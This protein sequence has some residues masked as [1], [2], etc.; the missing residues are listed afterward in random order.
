MNYCL[1]KTCYN[2]PYFFKT[3]TQDFRF[4]LVKRILVL[5]NILISFVMLCL[6]FSSVSSVQAQSQVQVKHYTTDEGL[7]HNIGFDILQDSK[8]YIWIGTDNG[9][10]R[11]DG[12]NFKVYRNSDGLLSNYVIG[13]TEAKDSSLWIGTWKGGVNVLK[14]GIIRTPKIDFPLFNI[15]YIGVNN[16]QLLLSDFKNKVFPY[17]KSANGWKY[18]HNKKK[19]F[20]Y[21]K[22]DSSIVYTDIRLSEKRYKQEGLKK[23]SYINTYLAQDHSILFFGNYPGVWKYHNDS[24]FTPF[25]PEF[26]KQEVIFCF[27]QDSDQ[28]Y[29]LGSRGKIITIDRQKKV[30]V[31]SQGLPAKYIYMLKVNSRGQIYFITNS[32]ARGI[33]DGFYSYNPRTKELIDLKERLALKSLPS[34]IEIDKEDNVWLTTNGDG[35]YCISSSLVKNYDDK[36]G[37]S[38]VFVEAINE[39]PLGNI[40]VGTLDGLYV[41]KKEQLNKLQLFA[42][43]ARY[44]VAGL[45]IDRNKKLLVTGNGKGSFL[46]EANSKG[47]K[48]SPKKNIQYK[49]YQDSKGDLW[50]VSSGAR[51]IRQRYLNSSSV[52][53]YEWMDLS[54]AKLSVNQIFEYNYQIWLATNAGLLSFEAAQFSGS[55][56][57]LQFTDTLNTVHGL[58]TNNVKMVAKDAQGVLWVATSNGLCK[59]QNNKFT[60]FDK[61]DGLV[62]NDCT[63]LLFD[64][65]GRLWIGT[66]KGLSCF[67]G[68]KFT[69]YNHKTGLISSDIHCLFLDSKQRLWVGTSKGVS[70]MNLSAL[71]QKTT[72]PLVY[73][74]AIEIN[75]AT[76]TL[77]PSL[78]KLD[79]EA[80][81]RVHFN[82][83]TYTYPEGVRFQYRLNGGRWQATSLNSIDFNALRSG[84]YTFEVRAKKMNSDWSLP[85]KL[86][87][88]VMP[89]FWWTKSAITAYI[90]LF[91]L[92]TYLVVKWRFRRLQK[93][94]L[95]LEALVT[96][97]TYELEQQKEEIEAQSNQLK[98]MDKMKS[99]FFSNI[100]HE[101]RTPLTLIIAPARKLLE[102]LNKQYIK[103]YSQTIIAN[104]ER[105]LR[106]INQLLDLA[107]LENKKMTPRLNIM[108]VTGYLQGIVS[109]FYVLAR[110]KNIELNLKGFSEEIVCEFDDD[111]L[112]KVFLN[113]L[114]NAFKFT[115]ENGRISVTVAKKAEMLEVSVEDT[116]IGIPEKSL[117]FI[118][119]RFYQLDTT[120]TREY[121]G[122]GVGLALT[123]E[124]IELHQGTI[125]VNSVLGKGTTFWVKLPIIT[126]A[127]PQIAKMTEE[128]AGFPSEDIVDAGLVSADYEQDFASEKKTAKDKVLIVE[129][130][131]E[132]RKFICIQLAPFYEVLEAN[133]GEEG[134][135]KALE[136]VPDLI[137]SDIMMPKVDG[138]ELLYTLRNNPLTSH[139]SILMLSAKASEESKIKGLKTG[140][141]D[142]LTKPFNVQELLLKIKNTLQRREQLRSLFLQSVSKPHVAIEP[143]QVTSVSMDEAFLTKAIET[144]EQHMGNPEFGAAFFYKEMGMSQSSLFR[145]LKALTGL[146]VTEFIRTI[147]LKR[148]ASLIQ[149]KVGTVEEVAFQAGF[150]DMSYFYRCFKKQ[151]GV[152]P[153]E[154]QK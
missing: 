58:A 2:L 84:M 30:S 70:M 99:R 140:G 133:N 34:F 4:F 101:F 126:Q 150:N 89:P 13:L 56:K 93:E 61:N 11:F 63:S 7:P 118:F 6:I 3:N 132:L 117:P 17:V 103:M 127:M 54:K 134:I 55:N 22:E 47:Y 114:S 82:G 53:E 136:V 8:G 87:F 79:Y 19:R 9:L 42:D 109:S 65:L 10:A 40:Y 88:Q 135:A 76:K 38:N 100:S 43:S 119:D 130:N 81:L 97:R 57:T 24:T 16:N 29:W 112:E 113:L 105:L 108:D 69:N 90:I 128:K 104:A 139:I 67:D 73:I 59:L 123:K 85:K 52:S 14:D 124:F 143:S 44:E 153:T 141:D 1:Y 12:K 121:E 115:P 147:K 142:Y 149:Q 120:Q 116:G 77:T 131:S 37:L 96:K 64:H 5:K 51:L 20:L 39:D 18:S 125:E 26:I 45:L 31:I 146:S 21:L 66:S 154:Y 25:Y 50:F 23:V 60:C 106:L 138:F 68:K 49:Q 92:I 144:V 110:Q 83:L 35:V 107:Q 129:D 15:S 72:P 80:I 148:A 95:K 28:K 78:L 36:H 48:V 152:T 94:K 151:F 75:G 74:D 32:R 145:K 98:E 137:I 111:K 71:P 27:S 91:V 46:L 41:Y 62:D 102:P 33:N 86:T 122:S